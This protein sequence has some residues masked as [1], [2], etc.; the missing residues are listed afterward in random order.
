MSNYII[1]LIPQKADAF[2]YNYMYTS[3]KKKNTNTNWFDILI[4]YTPK[5]VKRLQN[6]YKKKL[7]H[8]FL[9]MFML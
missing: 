5:K 7:S 2:M 3:Y 8:Q 9:T 1:Q 4:K 6:I